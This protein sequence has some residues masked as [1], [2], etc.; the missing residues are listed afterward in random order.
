EDSAKPVVAAIDGTA[1]GGG[2]E[3]ALGAHHRVA[4]ASSKVGLPEVKLGLIPGAGG[5][6]RLP[7][8]L[9][10]V[11]VAEIVATGA[12]RTAAAIARID[13]QRLFDRVVDSSDE[14]MA[15]AL[16]LARTAADGTPVRTRD[17]EP[18]GGGDLDA[19]GERVRRRAR[20]QEAPVVG[21][22]LVRTA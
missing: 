18:V 21:R 10:A 19:V 16:E 9:D 22:D 8:L 3:L 20:G 4:T 1:F 5:T 7:R 13:G 11:T 6:Q 17:R 2:L 12:P 15:A 14:L